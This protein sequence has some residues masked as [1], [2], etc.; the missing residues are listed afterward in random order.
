MSDKLRAEFMDIVNAAF[1]KITVAAAAN[2]VDSN[3]I[4]ELIAERDSLKNIIINHQATIESQAGRID[5]LHGLVRRNEQLAEKQ[6]EK[7]AHL[8]TLAGNTCCL[9][10]RDLQSKIDEQSER[11]VDLESLLDK[12]R[13]HTEADGRTMVRENVKR[14]ALMGENADLGFRLIKAKERSKVLSDAVLSRDKQLKEKDL[15][16]AGLRSNNSGELFAKQISEARDAIQTKFDEQSEAYQYLEI[17]RDSIRRS[18]QARKNR[19]REIRKIA[20][21]ADMGG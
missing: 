14:S 8:Q 13:E 1:E 6:V 20:E 11:I 16:I 15:S 3:A 12:Q 5:S 9:R 21:I 10:T 4:E 2:P 7:I 18:L 17:K 19:L